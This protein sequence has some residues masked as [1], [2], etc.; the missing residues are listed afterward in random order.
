MFSG[1]KVWGAFGSKRKFQTNIYWPLFAQI[2]RGRQNSEEEMFGWNPIQVRMLITH[3]PFK[4]KDTNESMPRED[5][6]AVKRFLVPPNPAKCSKDRDTWS[7]HVM[8]TYSREGTAEGGQPLQSRLSSAS[9]WRQ[10][11]SEGRSCYAR[12]FGVPATQT[13]LGIAARPQ[14]CGL[15]TQRR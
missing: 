11:F 8:L 4:P 5:F 15:C 2:R 9:M 6:K 13:K 7:S 12:L 14:W 3:G 1:S 10:S